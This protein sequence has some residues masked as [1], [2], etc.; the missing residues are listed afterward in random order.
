MTYDFLGDE[1]FQT[2]KSLQQKILEL[3]NE[4]KTLK[5]IQKNQSKDL[6]KFSEG[7]HINLLRQFQD[8]LRIARNKVKDLEEEKKRFKTD[9]RKVIDKI[10]NLEEKLKNEVA[11]NK[12]N[13]DELK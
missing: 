13:E 6:I 5:N 3:Q 10:C 8:E 1:S 11:K 7:D 12:Q 9:D 4:V 2:I